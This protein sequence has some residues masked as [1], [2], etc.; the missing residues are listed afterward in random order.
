VTGGEM[1]IWSAGVRWWLTPFM[2]L[3]LNYRYITLDGPGLSNDPALSD[4]NSTGIN[5]RLVLMLE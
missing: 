1:D 3:D 4:G 2:S 5:G